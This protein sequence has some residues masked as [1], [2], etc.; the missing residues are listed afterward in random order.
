MEKQKQRQRQWPIIF[1]LSKKQT[2]PHWTCAGFGGKLNFQ[3]LGFF[4]AGRIP[5]AGSFQRFSN[6]SAIK[7]K[8]YIRTKKNKFIQ[9]V[10]ESIQ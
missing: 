6:K 3:V 5:E 7:N 9:A 4:D 2:L 8:G 10:K 1:M